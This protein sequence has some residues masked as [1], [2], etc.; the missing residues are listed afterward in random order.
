[1]NLCLKGASRHGAITDLWFL[2]SWHRL[3]LVALT[4]NDGWI[5]AVMFPYIYILMTAVSEMS[6]SVFNNG[7]ESID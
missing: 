1:M 7:I 4:K 2:L 3:P 6:I 5:S